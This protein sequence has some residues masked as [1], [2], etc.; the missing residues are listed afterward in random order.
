MKYLKSLTVSL[1][2]NLL[3]TKVHKETNVGMISPID[4]RCSYESKDLICLNFLGWIFTVNCYWEY[5]YI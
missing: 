1:H 3:K 4:P 2:K 5:K